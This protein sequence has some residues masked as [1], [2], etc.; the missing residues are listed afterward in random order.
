[1]AL[2]ALSPSEHF[3]ISAAFPVPFF[4]RALGEGAEGRHWCSARSQNKNKDFSKVCSLS[5]KRR[6]QQKDFS[7][8][9]SAPQA[10]ERKTISENTK[11]KKFW[12][13]HCS[14]QRST[15]SLTCKSSQCCAA[16]GESRT[17]DNAN[18][19][20]KPLNPIFMKCLTSS[21]YWSDLQMAHACDKDSN[22]VDR[23][24]HIC[25]NVCVYKHMQKI[26]L[27]SKQQKLF[28]PPNWC[29][30]WYATL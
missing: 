15:E 24:S 29:V 5:L 26:W 30:L 27:K 4:C 19:L 3:C 2:G 13:W 23:F 17:E 21:L 28:L 14:E 6:Y 16:C 7:V 9:P 12:A 18:N 22:L 8:S 20:L 25:I 11:E 10:V 1:M